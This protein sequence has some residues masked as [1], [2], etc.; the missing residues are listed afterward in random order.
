MT[1]KKPLLFMSDLTGHIY[2]S[3]SYT[4]KANGLI[5]SKTKYDVTE[6]FE[7]IEARRRDDDTGRNQT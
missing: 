3:T 6:E 4:V 1:V 7:A 5:V 2:V